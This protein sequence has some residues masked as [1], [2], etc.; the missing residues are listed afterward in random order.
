MSYLSVLNYKERANQLTG[1]Y[2][3]ATLGFN[4]LITIILKD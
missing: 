2:M 3:I 4:E 1:I